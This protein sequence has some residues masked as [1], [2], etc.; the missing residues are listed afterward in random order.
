M[1]GKI[2]NTSRF[3][4]PMKEI[5][6]FILIMSPIIIIFLL[7]LAG[8]NGFNP[9]PGLGFVISFCIVYALLH[10]LQGLIGQREVGD[11]IN[12]MQSVCGIFDIGDVSQLPSIRLVFHW[13]T[14]AYLATH[15]FFQSNLKFT[16]SDDILYPAIFLSVIV[17]LSFGD[18]IRLWRRKCFIGTDSRDYILSL[19]IGGVLGLSLAF[20]SGTLVPN[21][22]FF[23]KMNLL[24]QC[25]EN[26]KCNVHALKPF[27]QLFK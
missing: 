9:F 22:I 3:L 15:L 16:E 20:A 24:S 17:I 14:M 4:V 19:L 12:S 7:F 1:A 13:F 10:L 25:D 27:L 5:P 18:V 8:G 6:Y 11:I 21:M 2:T 23:K 26:N